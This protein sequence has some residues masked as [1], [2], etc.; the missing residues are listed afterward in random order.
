MNQRQLFFDSLYDLMSTDERI[1][2]VT[3]DLGFGFADAIKQDFPERFF[4]VGAAELTGM[5]VCVG[6]AYSGKIPVF[7]SITPFAIFRPMEVIRNYVNHEKTPVLIVGS[8]R[9]ID[10]ERDGFSHDATDHD[11]MKTFKNITFIE[12][13]G[14]F[15]LKEILYNSLPAYLNLKR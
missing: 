6:L 3:A 10:Y 12:P 2:F 1:N 13:E 7:Y 8:G 11:I 15:D 14:D 9:G 5:G 4:N